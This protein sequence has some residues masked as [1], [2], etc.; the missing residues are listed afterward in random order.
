MCVC[1]CVCGWVGGWVCVCGCVW[2]Y[3]C[4]CV[5]VGGWMGVCVSE[6]K[7]DRFEGTISVYTIVYESEC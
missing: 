5:C 3:V 7:M 4:V 1:V 6:W 2:V